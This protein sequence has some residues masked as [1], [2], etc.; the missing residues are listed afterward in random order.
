MK[1]REW[2]RKH[3]VVHCTWNGKQVLSSFITFLVL[4]VHQC[5]I[6]VIV[7]MSHTLNEMQALS[8]FLQRI[9][10]ILLESKKSQHLTEAVRVWF[11]GGTLLLIMQ[12]AMMHCSLWS[13][14][15]RKSPFFF[16]HRNTFHVKQHMNDSTSLVK[17][18]NVLTKYESIFNLAHYSLNVVDQVQFL[19]KLEEPETSKR[20]SN[21]SK[22][23]FTLYSTQ[24]RAEARPR[25][26][27]SQRMI[28]IGR[29]P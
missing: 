24:H 29:L 20:C 11:G 25:I 8:V 23:S 26:F 1:R 27:D 15:L 5:W 12:S 10:I 2:L 7:D 16:Y 19:L 6:A 14:P 21:S 3:N 13:Q 18:Q 22:I 28:E 9:H 17:V 4:R